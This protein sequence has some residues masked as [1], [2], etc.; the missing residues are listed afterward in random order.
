MAQHR[1]GKTVARA[2][3][4]CEC[5]LGS[6]GLKLGGL[7]AADGPGVL[8]QKKTTWQSHFL[9]AF[10]GGRTRAN[11]VVLRLGF[12]CYAVLVIASTNTC[13]PI[14]KTASRGVPID[15]WQWIEGQ[16]RYR[17]MKHFLP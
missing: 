7:N 4:Y 16:R 1:N 10:V 8:A 15:V 2:S 17:E 6:T 5:R 11:G 14:E 9:C 3:G 13:N 12:H